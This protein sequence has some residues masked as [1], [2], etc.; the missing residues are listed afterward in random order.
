MVY[1]LLVAAPVAVL[2]AGL[3]VWVRRARRRAR[4]DAASFLGARTVLL[5]SDACSFGRQSRGV[6]QIRGNGILACTDQELW[7][8]MLAPAR[9]LTIPLETITALDTPRSHLGKGCIRPLLLVRFHSASGDDAVAW[10]VADLER[11]LTTL[12]QR[13]GVQRST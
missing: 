1:P 12:E 13:T 2:L 11:W 9:T 4:E 6:A 8:R 10:S 5:C 3:L 7:F